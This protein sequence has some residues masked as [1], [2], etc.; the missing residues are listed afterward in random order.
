MAF[1]N[2]HLQ[3]NSSIGGCYHCVNVFN[4]SDV[5]YYTDNGETA[6][7]PKCMIDCV[8]F[9]S[10]GYTITTENMQKAKNYWF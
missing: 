3:S 4:A 6:L 2:K 9:D 1:R 10:T 5:K 7:C 8:V